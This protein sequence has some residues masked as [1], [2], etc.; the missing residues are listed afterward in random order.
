MTT[1]GHLLTY[2]NTNIYWVFNYVSEI[3]LSLQLSHFISSSPFESVPIVSPLY[4]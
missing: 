3:V 2:N 1:A 4:R